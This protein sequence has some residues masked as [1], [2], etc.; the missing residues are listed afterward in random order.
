MEPPQ[1]GSGL[2]HAMQRALRPLEPPKQAAWFGLARSESPG[3]TGSLKVG[4]PFGRDSRRTARSRYKRLA[5]AVRGA[6][7][8]AIFLRKPL[9][10]AGLRKD[11]DEVSSMISFTRPL[12]APGLRRSAE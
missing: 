5:A 8:L 4:S 3:A 6:L 12:V 7:E 11:A 10:G 1:A 2:Q 9:R